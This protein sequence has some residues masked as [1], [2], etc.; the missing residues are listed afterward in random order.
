MKRKYKIPKYKT[1]HFIGIGGGGMS[2][3]AKVLLEKGYS[4]SGSDLKET[5]TTIRLKDLGA[6][7]FIGHNVTNL[8][9]ADY[10]VVSSAVPEDNKELIYAKQEKMHIFR[11]AEML[12]YVMEKYSN[13]I[14]VSGT[15]GKTTTTSMITRVLEMADKKPTYLIGAEFKDYGGN[16]CL[17]TSDYFVCEADESDG[18]FLDL[19]PNIAIVTNIEEEHMEYYKKLD[20][21]LKHF[22]TFMDKT[23][24]KGGHLIV[25][26]DDERIMQIAQKIDPKQITFF[27]V[28][29]PAQIMARDLSYSPEG[30]R[31]KLDINN[32]NHGD[33]YLRIHGIHN[34]Y[35]SLAAIALGIKEGIRLDT[36]KKSLLSFIGAKRRFQLMGEVQGIQVFD[37][38]GHHPTEIKVTLDSIKKSFGKKVVCIFQPHRYSRTRDLLERFPEA[39]D[40]A[41]KVVI[42]EIYSAYE[43]KIE[44]ISGKLIQKKMV[45]QN[46]RHAQFI[47]NKSEIAPKI[48]KEIDKGD[49]VITMGAGNIHTVAKEI[50]SQLKNQVEEKDVK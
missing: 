27:S 19:S 41:D 32:K 21:L 14:A 38:Y 47:A 17:G 3:I 35:N 45:E 18:S 20:N 16:A 6:T 5:I 42:T 48:I 13:K 39:F 43:D 44:G 22:N 26:K 46:K 10:V 28:N 23:L 29:A 31:Y 25:N 1:I 15:H 34:V 36:I 12:N 2:A 11:R 33:V 24:H 4:V 40:A 30:V 37:D 7:I 50:I 8:R 9:K 49:I